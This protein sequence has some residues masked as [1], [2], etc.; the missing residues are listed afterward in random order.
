MTVRRHAT[1]SLLPLLAGLLLSA[2]GTARGGA[3]TITL[4][5]G[6]HEQTTALLVARF[7]RRTGIKVELRSGDEA[8]LGN[9]IL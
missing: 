7:E 6:Q 2:C 9:Q 3:N 5:S 8:S 4:Y 1:L